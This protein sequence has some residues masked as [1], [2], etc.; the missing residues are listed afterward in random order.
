M[1]KRKPSLVSRFPHEILSLGKATEISLD[2]ACGQYQKLLLILTKYHQLPA[3]AF[4][5]LLVG[6]VHDRM[7]EMPY[8]EPLQSFETGL[9]PEPTQVVRIMEE[10]R[11][12]LEQV[13]IA[14]G[15]GLLHETIV[16]GANPFTSS[17]FS[18]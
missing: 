7:T 14:R 3:N 4:F 13:C 15:N 10:G 8:P 18:F 6:L 2:L 11:A 9:T 1:S 16:A 5:P 17:A 12:A